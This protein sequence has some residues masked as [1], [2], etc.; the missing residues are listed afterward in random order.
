MTIKTLAIAS[1]L[2]TGVFIFACTPSD[3]TLKKEVNE[4]LSLVPGITAEVKNGVVI[5]SGEVSD[6]VAKSAAEDALRGVKGVKSIMDSITV[7]AALPETP[8][9]APIVLSPDEIL[10]K[11]LD[12]V[13]AAGGFSDITVTVANGEVT[14][15]GT[16]Q[17]KQLRKVKQI[18]QQLGGK[19]VVSNVK[20]K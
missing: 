6:D 1:I 20:P 8:A 9:P 15:D 10:K 16:A 17:K 12:S 18:A 3:A 11:N 13:Y 5:L 14:L 4:R 2:F 7:K 19:K